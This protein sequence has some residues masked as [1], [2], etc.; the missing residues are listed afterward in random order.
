MHIIIKTLLV[1]IGATFAM[2]IWSFILKLFKISSLDY[3]FVGRWIGNI[4]NGQ[5]FHKGIMNSPAIKHELIIGWVSHY[6]IGISFA[7]MLLFIY[8]KGWF[9]KPMLFPALVIGIATIVAPFFLMQPAFGL[10]IAGAN[11]PEPDILRLKSFMAHVIYGI[12]LY[13]SAIAVNII[14]KV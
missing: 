3:R 8:G 4:P 11:V 7:Y 12:G 1:G 14:F 9:A 13:I 6:L 2:D 5:F 10:G